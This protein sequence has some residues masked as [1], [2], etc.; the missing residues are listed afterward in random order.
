M[1]P[2]PAAAEQL[3]QLSLIQAMCRACNPAMALLQAKI[4]AFASAEHFTGD[5]KSASSMPCGP[6]DELD[7]WLD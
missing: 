3:L 4:H 6:G 2:K 1:A 7:R 5:T